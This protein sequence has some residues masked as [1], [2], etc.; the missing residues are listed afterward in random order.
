M[1]VQLAA[2]AAAEM[3]SRHIAFMS[4]EIRNPVNG[5]LAS[6]E[7]LDELLPALQRS[8]A[9]RAGAGGEVG[10]CRFTSV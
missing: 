5:I 7:A 4:H 9:D 10:R 3:R 1:A 8:R 6:V 2:E